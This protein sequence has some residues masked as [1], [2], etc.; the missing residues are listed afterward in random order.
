MT[1]SLRIATKLVAYFFGGHLVSCCIV[2]VYLIIVV[3][4]VFENTK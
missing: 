2:Y 4:M 1:D 3:V